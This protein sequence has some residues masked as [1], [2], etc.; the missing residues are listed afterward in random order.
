MTVH[1]RS[2]TVDD[3]GIIAAIHVE[4]RA[5]GYRNIVPPPVLSA[6]A[7]V[8][9]RT[10]QWQ[11][12][13]QKT[14]C[15]VGFDDQNNPVGFC[16]FGPVR[17]R[18]PSDKGV[19]PRFGEKFMPYMCIRTIGVMDMDRNYCGPDFPVCRK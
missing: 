15:V 17:T 3:A 10:E 4:S 9:E 5:Q 13:L 6:E 1:I 18:L 14:S 11:D 2:A 8:Q 16:A 12:W 19:M 7:T